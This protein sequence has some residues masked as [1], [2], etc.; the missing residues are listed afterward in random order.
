MYYSSSNFYGTDSSTNRRFV[1]MAS[2]SAG[3][4]TFV[5]YFDSNGFLTAEG[6][7]SYSAASDTL[8]VVN[9]NIAKMVANSSAGVLF[10]ANN[11]TDI[12]LF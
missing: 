6:T 8:S 12:A 2:S 1:R 7:F 5:P 11:G 4:S 10:E 9:I 3:G